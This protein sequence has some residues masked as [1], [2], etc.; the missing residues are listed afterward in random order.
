MNCEEFFSNF[1]IYELFFTVSNPNIFTEFYV[2][3]VSNQTTIISIFLEE[4]LLICQKK[5][6]I[7]FVFFQWTIHS[8]FFLN[9][10]SFFRG[11]NRGLFGPYIYFFSFL[12]C[13]Y[14]KVLWLYT[15]SIAS[16]T[17]KTFNVL[18]VCIS[19]NPDWSCL[20]AT[21]YKCKLS[22]L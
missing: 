4:I 10:I 8:Q 14:L 15:L 2:A 22:M 11:K 20:E 5:F 7:S 1:I 3:L 19:R 9:T 6:F 17:S 12:V 18:K 21:I 16:D 13:I